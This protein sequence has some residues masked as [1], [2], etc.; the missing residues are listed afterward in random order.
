[1]F[2]QDDWKITSR[3]TLNLGLRYEIPVPP[4]EK[5]GQVTNFLPETKTL[6]IGSAKLLPAGVT[7]SNPNGIVFADQAGL[8]QLAYTRYNDFAPRIGFAWRPFGGNRFVVR[9]GYG[10][11]F[12]GNQAN[13]LRNQLANN[14]FPF[15]VTQQIVRNAADPNFLT[16][17]NPFPTPANLS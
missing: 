17:A 1:W 8:P 4:H 9:S 11:F 3:L 15:G 16:F 6:V 5:Y 14:T 12:G 7:F 13:P 2:A 10:T